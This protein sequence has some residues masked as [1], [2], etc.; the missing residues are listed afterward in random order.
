MT[1]ESRQSS[2]APISGEELRIKIQHSIAQSV[3]QKA[4]HEFGVLAQQLT[5]A[6]LRQLSTELTAVADTP[7]PQAESYINI[8]KESI[9]YL[10]GKFSDPKN[11]GHSHLSSWMRTMGR[12]KSLLGRLD[13]AVYDYSLSHNSSDL[14]RILYP[15]LSERLQA[16]ELFRQACQAFA[17]EQREQ[18]LDHLARTLELDF[19]FAA[20][21]YLRGSILIDLKRYRFAVEELSRALELCPQMAEAW[22]QRGLAYRNLRDYD[23]ARNDLDRA[24]ALKPDSSTA[25]TARGIVYRARGEHQKA[26]ADFNRALELDPENFQAYNNRANALWEHGEHDRA[27]EDYHRALEINPKYVQ[28]LN[29]RGNLYRDLKEYDRALADFA[30]A[31]EIDPQHAFVFI[32]RGNVFAD[33]KRYQEAIAEYTRAIELD[34]ENPDAYNNRGIVLSDLGQNESALNDFSQAIA[35]DERHA[36]AYTNRAIIYSDTG[37]IDLAI[38]DYQQAIALRPRESTNH[39]N[40]AEI[41]LVND[42]YQEL[43]ACLNRAEPQ[44]TEEGDRAVLFYLRSLALRLLEMDSLE[45][46]LCF[47]KSLSRVSYVSWSFEA[48]D[49]WLKKAALP[50][51]TRSQIVRLTEQLREKT[52]L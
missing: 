41:F 32:N 45:S 46:D 44:L 20:A 7:F 23:R 47:Q 48:I 33:L 36:N 3:A 17:E 4:R 49:Q 12:L 52:R 13:Q 11:A 26:M 16:V 8:I 38:A 29:N 40:L 39:L 10:A 42:R 2:E 21:F 50:D 1:Q 30:Q 37:K 18:A 22:R 24:L 34:P 27:L 15:I 9:A 35:L 14:H 19:E 28:A 43:L 6:R 25:L 31:L 5:S 51:E